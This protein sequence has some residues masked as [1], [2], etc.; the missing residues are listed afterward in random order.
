M[1]AMLPG[2]GASARIAGTPIATEI[3]TPARTA[4]H[5]IFGAVR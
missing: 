1:V 2:M 5:L 3:A 4:L